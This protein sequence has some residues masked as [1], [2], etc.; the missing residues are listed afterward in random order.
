MLSFLELA[1]SSLRSRMR[2]RPE[3]VIVK[4]CLRSMMMCF[5]LHLMQ[6]CFFMEESA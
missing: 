4:V 1:D 6:N 2:P 5:G 3:E